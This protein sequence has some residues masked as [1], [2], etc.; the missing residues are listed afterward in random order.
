MNSH[1]ANGHFCEQFR[2]LRG[3][4]E[5]KETGEPRVT[6]LIDRLYTCNLTKLPWSTKFRKNLYLEP[7]QFC[8][9]PRIQRGRRW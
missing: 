1:Y 9:L 4:V 6:V 5:E 7:T 2:L 3:F 8:D